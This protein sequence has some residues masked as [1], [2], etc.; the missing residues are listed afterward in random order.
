LSFATPNLVS[1]TA[2]PK[3]SH[4]AAK[5]RRARE[6]PS[7]EAKRRENMVIA[8]RLRGTAGAAAKGG[9]QEFVVATYHMPC[10]YWAPKVMTI[11]TS[12]LFQFVSDFAKGH[13]HVVAG[14]F[15]FSP[16]DSLYAFVRTSFMDRK[17]PAF[18]EPF[19]NTDVWDVSMP[20]G[21]YRSAYHEADG[22]EPEFTNYAKVKDEPEFIDTLDYL[23]FHAPGGYAM[24]VVDT[25]KLPALKSVQGPLPTVHEP[26]DHIMI[27]ATFDLK[28]SASTAGSSSS[29]FST[30]AVDGD[31][32]GGNLA[33]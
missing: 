1:A 5:V 30:T 8:A 20:Y 32:A 33:K 3:E 11:H 7:L 28:D 21:G 22:I 29:S 27:A 23:F 31:V 25:L 4:Q 10:V 15:N 6:N 2:A 16:S 19:D 26:S 18:P 12:L 14:D 13:P 24:K 9:S 17:D